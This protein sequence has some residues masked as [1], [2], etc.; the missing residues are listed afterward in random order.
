MHA[1]SA[2]VGVAV[3]NMLPN[4]TVNGNAGVTAPALANLANYLSPANEFFFLA[5]NAT[6][7]VFDGFT[8]LHQKRAAEAAFDQAAAQYRVTVISSLQNVADTLRAL[9]GD[10]NSLK[11]A[12]EFERA[13]KIS[14]DLVRQ[15][16]ETGY[17]NIILLL[18][19]QQTYLQA[20]IAVIQARANRLADTVAL[21]QAL[22]GG[23]WNREK[24]L[25]DVRN[26]N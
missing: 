19:A 25:A 8:L 18:N 10:A 11:A 24:V 7:T 12:A 20:R 6:Q 4:F 22:G 13:A 15:Q 9:Q 3:A 1:A 16:F 14:F 2:Q 5:G 26:E 17:A 21:F 23:W